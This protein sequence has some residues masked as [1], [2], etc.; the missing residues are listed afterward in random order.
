VLDGRWGVENIAIAVPKGRESAQ[1][2]LRGFA[3]KMRDSGEL[4]NMMDRAGMRGAAR[5]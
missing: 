4:Q 5:D 1:R 2:F 3:R